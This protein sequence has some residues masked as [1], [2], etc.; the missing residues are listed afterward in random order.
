VR[1]LALAA[2][3]LLGGCSSSHF[4]AFQ[5]NT[6]Q[7]FSAWVSQVRAESTTAADAVVCIARWQSENMRYEPGVRFVWPSYLDAWGTTTNC[8]GYARVALE[9]LARL[10]YA[11]FRMLEVGDA[12]SWHVVTTDR[13]RLISNG[14]L[15]LLPENLTWSDVA[16]RVKPGW[17]DYAVRDRDLAVDERNVK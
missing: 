7:A 3:L 5:T 9:A 15:D 14:R 10:G 4:Q 13:K 2:L 17:T 1:V 11:D 6:E 8:A 12:D 16:S